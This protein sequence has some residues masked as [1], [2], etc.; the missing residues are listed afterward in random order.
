METARGRWF[1]S[2]YARRLRAADT[3]RLLAAIE[4]LER[5]LSLVTGDGAVVA[6]EAA[7]RLSDR[8]Q[9]FA[10]ALRERGLDESVC[11]EIEA[12]AR[13]ARHLGERSAG[14]EAPPIAESVAREE[15][16]IVKKKA[17]SEAKATRPTRQV[18][19]P[20][21]RVVEP[22]PEPQGWRAARDSR[23]DALLWLDRLPLV[24]K[25]ALFA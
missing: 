9:D 1:L 5:R 3:D 14:D 17:P 22:A 19:A 6:P 11:A 24:D 12:R 13:E 8:L 15:T 23:V 18:G 25:L 21:S 10:W 2:E 16:P 20:P 4:R 7:A